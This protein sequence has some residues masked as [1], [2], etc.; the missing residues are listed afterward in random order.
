[1]AK[2]KALTGS[3]V[4]WLNFSL[5]S[6]YTLVEAARILVRRSL[7]RKNFEN[8]LG[9]DKVGSSSVGSSLFGTHCTFIFIFLFYVS[10]C[11][12]FCVCACMCAGG[13]PTDNT[14]LSLMLQITSRDYCL[15]KKVLNYWSLSV[16]L[17][18]CFSTLAMLVSGTLHLT[19]DISVWTINCE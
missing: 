19:C 10:F 12:Y 7:E 1:M 11:Q 8:R 2:Y 14:K 17:W 5:L 6:L 18:N 15:A 9:F 13:H 3:A 16:C 4:K